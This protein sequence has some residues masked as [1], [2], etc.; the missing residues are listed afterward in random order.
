MTYC[1]RIHT[2]SARINVSGKRKRKVIKR[3]RHQ[4]KV[5]EEEEDDG[6]A[7][8]NGIYQ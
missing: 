5:A 6:E 4:R 8:N 7:E 2:K 1:Y 3:L